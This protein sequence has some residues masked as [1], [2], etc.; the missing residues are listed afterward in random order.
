MAELFGILA[1]IFGY[2]FT[3]VTVGPKLF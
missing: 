1:D 2:V 3:I